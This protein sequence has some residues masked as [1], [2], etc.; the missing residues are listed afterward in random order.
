M[1]AADIIF[2][3]LRQL[4]I[5]PLFFATFSALSYYSRF[6][7]VCLADAAIFSQAYSHCHADITPAGHCSLVDFHYL[8]LSMAM[9]GLPDIATLAF[10]TR[11]SCR[12]RL[13]A[14]CHVIIFAFAIIASFHHFRQRMIAALAAPLPR[15]CHAAS[16]RRRHCGDGCYA[17]L[18]ASIAPLLRRCAPLAAA[19]ADS[20]FTPL[21]RHFS[22]DAADADIFAF[23]IFA[24]ITAF[25]F[26]FRLFSFHFFIIF[27][28]FIFII[29]M[30]RHL[31]ICFRR[32]LPA[33]LAPA[34]PAS[35][36]P[37][38]LAASPGQRCHY[39]LRR[40]HDAPLTLPPAAAM[41]PWR[42]ATCRA[43]AIAA[44]L[45]V[46]SELAAAGYAEAYCAS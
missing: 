43:F 9:P 27:H 1:I 39:W 4:I 18:T 25:R 6:S 11:R 29:D 15:R 14:T 33:P 19:A 20:A 10:A 41:K 24:F 30:I 28:Y 36:T 34:P 31:L 7:S 17:M 21:M 45:T 3:T 37:L 32:Q 26:H 35:A 8:A 16:R 12:Q 44:M 5:A 23:L 22:A 42:C 2:A 46:T 13:R 38:L 40:C